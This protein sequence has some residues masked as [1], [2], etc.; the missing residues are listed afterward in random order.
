MPKV[1]IPNTP[2]KGKPSGA[3]LPARR[4]STP[5][6]RVY[7]KSPPLA[8][9]SDHRIIAIDPG[10]TT[11]IAARIDSKLWTCVATTNDEVLGMLDT[12]EYVVVERFETA[13]RLSAPGHHTINLVGEIV[14]WCKAKGI[15]YELCMPQQRWMMMT[16]ARG[17][18]GTLIEPS[19][20]A[21]HETDA[22][23]H[24]LA[25]EYRRRW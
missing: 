21:K 10:Y 18:V 17:A 6:G 12:M 13:G 19:K 9:P 16:E 5:R 4:A 8:P 25:F 14:G 2:Y 20:V 15:K 11:G 1:T 23:A 3:R 22:L 7:P 24:L